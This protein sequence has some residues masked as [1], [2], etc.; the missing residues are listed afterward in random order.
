MNQTQEDIGARTEAL[1]ELGYLGNNPPEL[2]A[3]CIAA[4]RLLLK[5]APITPGDIAAASG[6][7]PDRMGELFGLIPDCAYE[8][9]DRE[10]ITAFIGLSITPEKHKLIV[11]GETFYTW[12]AFDAL[13][14]PE[15]LGKEAEIITDCPASGAEIRV[16][17]TQKALLDITPAGAV[18]SLVAPDKDAYSQDLRG[19]FCCKVNF[20]RDRDAF[21]AWKPADQEITALS[22]ADAFALAQR[23]NAG[24]FPDIDLGAITGS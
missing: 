16:R 8:C 7:A 2:Q 4:Y 18:M 20:F 17:L 22:L 24:K 14:L 12:C 3:L 5:G 9:N 6:V 11:E 13:F 1:L 19:S 23:R 21:T 10:G 15:L